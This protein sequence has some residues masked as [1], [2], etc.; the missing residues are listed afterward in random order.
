M[1][2][3]KLGIIGFGEH[4]SRAHIKHLATDSRV[5]IVAIF[6][7]FLSH[8]KFIQQVQEYGIKEYQ[9]I[10]LFTNEEDFWNS[11]MDAVL[12][13][14]PDKFHASQMQRAIDLG[15]H[16]FCEKPMAVSHQDLDILRKT[17]ETAQQ[18][19]IVVASCHPRRFDS[20][21]IWLKEQI[22]SGKLEKSIGKVLHVDFTFWYRKVE[23]TP[24]YAWKKNRSLLS[25]HFGHE[26]DTVA[27]LFPEQMAYNLNALKITDSYRQYE[28]VGNSEAGLSYR[29][30][31][32]RTLDEIS[33]QE[34]IRIDGERG[35]WLLNLSKGIC[36]Y[37]PSTNMKAIPAIDY[38]L[39]FKKVNVNFIDAITGIN[40]N[41]LSH[42]DIL[43]N[44]T[45]S[46]QLDQEGISSYKQQ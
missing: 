23:D 18:K 26:I 14:S 40:T 7:P 37:M 8:D 28:V 41:Y 13:A 38:D 34:S 32:L 33:Y 35:S 6:D 16:I 2:I 11:S 42:S 31:G 24:E 25:D 29:F 44:N 39:R 1:N 43:R 46:V 5:K 3:V 4:C 30:L 9:D 22:D 10:A 20:P 21:F 45:M 19:N 17:L 12:I 36:I 27:F 15:L